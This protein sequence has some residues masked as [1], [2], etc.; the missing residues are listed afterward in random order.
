MEEEQE[1]KRENLFIPIQNNQ[2]RISQSLERIG[3]KLIL[4]I[5]SPVHIVYQLTNDFGIFMLL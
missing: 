1:R 4:P 2:T 5:L 3:D